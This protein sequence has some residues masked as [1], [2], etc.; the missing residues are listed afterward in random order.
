MINI[1][2]TYFPITNFLYAVRWPAGGTGDPRRVLGLHCL[3]SS[4]VVLI[5]WTALGRFMRWARQLACAGTEP[6]EQ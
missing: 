2:F 3:V 6:I 4:R 5:Q 1:C